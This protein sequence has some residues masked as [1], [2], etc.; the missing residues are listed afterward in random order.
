MSLVSGGW[1]CIRCGEPEGNHDDSN[2]RCPVYDGKKFVC[3]HAVNTFREA[4]TRDAS[5][6]TL[7]KDVSDVLDE[8]DE[9]ICKIPAEALARDGSEADFVMRVVDY[10]TLRRAICINLNA[11]P[12]TSQPGANS[13]QPGGSHYKD[14]AIQPWDFINENGIGF[15]AGNVI[16]YVARYEHKGGLL[17]LEK[18][19]HYLDKLIEVE[20]AK[21]KQPT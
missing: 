10:R 4:G 2:A 7:S 11:P 8:Y 13:R 15:L 12:T 17:D 1:I 19:K 21:A 14:R 20:E 16:K 3:Y 18:A 9:I 6:A 5:T